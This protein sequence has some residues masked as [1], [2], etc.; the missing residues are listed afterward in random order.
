MKENNR[1]QKSLNT[2]NPRALAQDPPKGANTEFVHTLYNLI[3]ITEQLETTMI[4]ADLHTKNI[5]HQQ[6][7]ILKQIYNHIFFLLKQRWIPS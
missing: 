6:S 1:I 3:Q 4:N 2:I 7:K 5:I